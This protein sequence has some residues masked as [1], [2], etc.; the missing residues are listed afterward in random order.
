MS[1]S[2]YF[3]KVPFRNAYLHVMNR[4]ASGCHHVRQL[5]ANEIDLVLDVGANN[6]QYA[7]G[8]IRNGYQGRIVSFEPL[9]CALKKLNLNR[10]AFPRWE[11]APLALGDEDKTT[12]FNVSGNTQSSSVLPMLPR[13]VAANPSTAYVES[14]EVQMNRLDSVI[15]QYCDASERVFLKLD[16]QGFEHQ[17]LAGAKAALSRIAGLKM[18]LSFQPLYENALNWIDSIQA[19]EELGYCMHWIEP[20]FIDPASGEMLQ[21]D[22]TFFRDRSGSVSRRAAA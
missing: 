11:V 2:L 20:G 4:F 6:G 10:F 9:P 21:G 5:K 18:E 1:S 12:R 7:R 14:I 8:L 16:V 13:H 17:V 19:C 15:D 3:A 22:A